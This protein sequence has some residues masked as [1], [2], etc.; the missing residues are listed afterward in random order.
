MPL[1]DFTCRGCDRTFEV[2]VRG[3][4]APAC[5]TCGGTDLEKQ[6]SLPGVQSE[7]TRALAMTAAKKRDKAQAT[8]RA[9]EQLRYER[10]HND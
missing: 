1:F 5:P 2:L 7:A 9:Q 6:L 10:S 4:E 8:E 3:R